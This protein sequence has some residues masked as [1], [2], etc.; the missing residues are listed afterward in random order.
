MEIGDGVEGGG[1]GDLDWMEEQDRKSVVVLS[2]FGRLVGLGLS[3]PYWVL[4]SL[5]SKNF[6]PSPPRP[7][8]ISPSRPVLDFDVVS[9]FEGVPSFIILSVFRF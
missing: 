9:P 4:L 1:G 8:L 5:L 6:W 2:S 3:G 7:C